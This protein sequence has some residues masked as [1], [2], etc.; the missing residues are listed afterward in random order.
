[1]STQFSFFRS[2]KQSFPGSMRGGSIFYFRNLMSRIPNRE[3]RKW[4]KK[5]VTE[6][7]PSVSTGTL[8]R[9]ADA[10]DGSK[11]PC[12]GCVQGAVL[13]A[14]CHLYTVHKKTPNMSRTEMKISTW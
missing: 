12:N 1:M 10:I 6:H 5:K 7:L 9:A 8:D 3:K 2:I 11:H 4:R 14:L 13:C